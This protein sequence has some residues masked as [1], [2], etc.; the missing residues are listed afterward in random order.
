[1][2]LSLPLMALPARAQAEA[3]AV[4]VDAAETE[5]VQAGDAAGDVEVEQRTTEEIDVTPAAPAQTAPAEQ[6]P[7][8]ET[9]PQAPASPRVLITEVIIEGLADHPEQERFQE[10]QAR[11]DDTEALTEAQHILVRCGAISFGCYH[12]IEGY[13]EACGQLR[14]LSLP[15][16]DALGKLLESLVQPSRE[17]F[18]RHG[19]ET[20]EVLRE[21]EAWRP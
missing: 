5:A 12:V 9:L 17:L 11:V 19:I 18:A 21:L 2:A 7:A 14:A 15:R 1:M 4:Q 16:A 3:E 10:L 20:P 8:A 6:A 13:R